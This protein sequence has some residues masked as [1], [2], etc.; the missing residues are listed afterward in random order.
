[1]TTS[2]RHHYLSEFYLRGFS[3]KNRIWV[4]DRETG[5]TRL[6]SP[7][8]TAVITHCYTIKEQDGSYNTEVESMFSSIETQA[9]DVINKLNDH[10][11]ITESEKQSLALF[12]GLLRVRVPQFEQILKDMFDAQAKSLIEVAF[13]TPERVASFIKQNQEKISESS[14]INAEEFADFVQ[15][16]EYKVTPHRNFTIANMLNCG[17]YVMHYLWQMDWFILH[18]QNDNMLITTDA[19]F[20]LFAPAYMTPPFRYGISLLKP[21][22]VKLVP[23]SKTCTLAMVDR[24]DKLLHRE[25]TKEQVQ[26]HN[27]ILTSLC[28]R[29]VIGSDE[30]NILDL[31]KNT[32]VDQSQSNSIVKIEKYGDMDGLLTVTKLEVAKYNSV[33]L[34]KLLQ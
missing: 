16:G 8:N 12:I 22:A 28:H 13:A 11:E 26:I 15:R 2:K 3:Q 21:G 1:M 32:K 29:L 24:G 19:P 31:I 23:L 17:L 10:K 9:V 5:K 6:D 14:S 7:H 34:G 18:S 4:F 33:W 27:E 30:K 25:L 20:T